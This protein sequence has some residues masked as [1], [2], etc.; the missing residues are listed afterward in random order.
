MARK[1]LTAPLAS[2]RCEV[3][4]TKVEAKDCQPGPVVCPTCGRWIA[5]AVAR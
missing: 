5:V 2:V 1:S 3:D 4:F